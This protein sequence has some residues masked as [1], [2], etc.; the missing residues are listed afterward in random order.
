[1]P[2]PERL[3]VCGLPLT[4]SAI[5]TMAVAAP[6]AAAN[7][8]PV[9]R[10]DRT[11][12]RPQAST[13]L[14]EWGT[15]STVVGGGPAAGATGI[16]NAL[17]SPT[18]LG[19]AD[20]YETAAL[21]AGFSLTHG[22]IPDRVMLVTGKSFPDAISSSSLAQ[23]ARAPLLLTRPDALAAPT[24]A[25]LEQHNDGIVAGFVAGGSDV[26]SDGVWSDARAHALLP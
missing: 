2:L 18:R 3:T 8:W 21:L 1:M 7:G 23:H 5:L 22:L 4:L 11:A 9:V 17:P 24:A 16:E 14:A 19:G 15:T 12:L 6:L 20:R 10:V 13:L 26:V 25:Y